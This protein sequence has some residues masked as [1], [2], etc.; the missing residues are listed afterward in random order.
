MKRTL[1]TV[2]LTVVAA[3]FAPR[4]GV[5]Y[6]WYYQ[7]LEDHHSLTE[8]TQTCVVCH[9]RGGTRSLNAYG[10]DFQAAGAN[11]AALANI[12]ARD[13]DGDGVGNEAELGT[14]HFPGDAT[15][16]PRPAE[17]AARAAGR[18]I[19]RDL[20]RELFESLQCPCCD[21]LVMN[22]RCDMVPEVRRIVDQGA[23]AR[24]SAEAIKAKLVTRFGRKILPLQERRETLPADRFTDRR[25]A[26]AYR[27]AAAI[28]LQLAKYPC[29]CPCYSG[30][31]H[32]GLLDCYKNEHGARCKTCIE[33]AEVIEAMVLDR[34]PEAEIRA[35]L[36]ERF[37][38]RH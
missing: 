9:A 22:C 30:N 7:L 29:F 23:A 12:A 34:R 35:R 11:A 38:G 3:S 25:V 20:A 2:T 17:V 36:V 31:G 14:G 19:P 32:L 8:R 6:N 28:P 4:E 26:N 1:V 13:S 37:G 18:R 5:G 15:D 10:V 16:V 21:K 24:E 33:E 27:I